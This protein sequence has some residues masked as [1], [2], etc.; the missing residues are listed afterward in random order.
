M[1]SQRTPINGGA[2][3]EEYSISRT[4]Y[5]LIYHRKRVRRWLRKVWLCL[6]SKISYRFDAWEPEDEAFTNNPALV[7]TPVMV[8]EEIMEDIPGATG[9]H[10]TL[11][12][13]GEGKSVIFGD[14]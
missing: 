12:T 6:L 7:G 4:P 13:D 11:A 1:A 2:R 8:A 5:G 10:Y 14:L 3:L 9:K